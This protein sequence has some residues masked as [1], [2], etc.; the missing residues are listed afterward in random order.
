MPWFLFYWAK[1]LVTSSS[2]I[3]TLPKFEP[4]STFHLTPYK[5][6]I[7]LVYCTQR[8][9]SSLAVHY[10]TFTLALTSTPYSRPITHHT[11][12]HS[13]LSSHH[14]PPSPSLLILSPL[15]LLVV[16]PNDLPIFRNYHYIHQHLV[17]HYKDISKQYPTVIQF[18]L[19]CQVP[20]AYELQWLSLV[21]TFHINT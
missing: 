3:H 10:T 15:N 7:A 1:L 16:F 21:S 6:H 4:L 20:A 8:L 11:R 9:L 13:S 18:K 5:P 17:M 19:H 12:H 14:S 2:T